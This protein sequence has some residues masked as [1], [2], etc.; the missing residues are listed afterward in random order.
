MTAGDVARLS[1]AYSAISPFLEPLLHRESRNYCRDITAQNIK[2]WLNQTRRAF[3]QRDKHQVVYDQPDDRYHDLNLQ[4]LR[5]HGT[6]EFRA[7]GPIY[8]YEHIVRWAWLCRE[9]TNVSKLNL[10]QT[11]WTSVRSMADVVK[12]LRTYGKEQVP[13]GIYKLYTK[14]DN[15]DVEY[16]QESNRQDF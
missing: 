6:I 16:T 11:I 4:A 13:E 14:G 15:L 7:L 2:H 8:D 9:L 5:G 3:D 1:V 12:I 10:P